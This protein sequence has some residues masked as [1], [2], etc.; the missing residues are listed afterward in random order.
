MVPNILASIKNS[1]ESRMH[2]SIILVLCLLCLAM[3][4]L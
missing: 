3:Y 1:V 4:L 2:I